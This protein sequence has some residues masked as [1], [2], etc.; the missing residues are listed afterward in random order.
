VARFLSA[1]WIAA[2]DQALRG[3]ARPGLSEPL[4]IQH[5]VTEGPDGE[6]AYHLRLDPAGSTAASGHA[7]DATVTF[8]QTYTT[9]A[10]ISSGSSSAQAAFMAGDLRLG[11][12]VDVLMAHHAAIAELDDVLA[13]VRA[14][15]EF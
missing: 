2:L 6:V 1:E 14:D 7:D 11:G 8:T 4:V 9:A 15:T 3:G 12:R 5:V 13:P 10:A